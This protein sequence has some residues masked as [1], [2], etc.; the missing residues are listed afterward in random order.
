MNVDLATRYYK[1]GFL[2]NEITFLDELAA[3]FLNLNPRNRFRLRS[4]PRLLASRYQRHDLGVGS[5]Q[6]KQ[7]PPHVVPKYNSRIN[8]AYSVYNL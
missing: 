8:Y 5:D 4:L 1:F 2:C 7:N 6:P 3:V